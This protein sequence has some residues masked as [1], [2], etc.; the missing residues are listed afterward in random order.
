MT[1]LFKPDGTA[2]DVHDDS[3]EHALSIGW[4]KSDPTVK[5]TKKTTIKANK[6]PIKSTQKAK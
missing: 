5:A 4:T 6:K 3:L 1:K 2:L